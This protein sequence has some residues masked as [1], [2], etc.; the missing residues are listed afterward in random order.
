MNPK[1]KDRKGAYVMKPG[2]AFEIKAFEFLKL[3][4]QNTSFE[5]KGGM[6]S[7]TSDIAVLKNNKID[8]FIEAKDTA[9]QSGQ[10]V[11][12]PDTNTKK[13]IFSPKNCSTPNDITDIIIQYMD[14]NFDYFHDAGTAGKILN[15]PSDIFAKWIIEHYQSR[16]VKY[17][18][19]C[20]ENFVILPI[21]KFA[22]YFDITATYRTKKSGSRKPAQKHINIVKRTIIECYP[23]A[24]FSQ[25]G[26]KL[27]MNID[28]SINKDHFIIGD[29]TYYLSKQDNNSYEVRCLSNTYNMNV[30][31]SI[32]LKKEQDSSDLTA[33]KS[34]LN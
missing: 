8:F 23:T 30:I 28:T 4:F 5:H 34:D 33:F 11:L 12:L 31:F 24:K 15:I 18:I 6:D 22:E 19:S 14:N 7:T 21:N 16:N 20:G 9:A 29:Y 1:K 27:Y 3:T 32:Q 10:F 2:E 17:V 26:Q 25:Q 13:F